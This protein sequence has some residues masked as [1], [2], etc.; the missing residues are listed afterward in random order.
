MAF[1]RGQV[2][3]FQVLKVMEMEKGWLALSR[4]RKEAK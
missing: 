2:A 4:R 3:V 1:C